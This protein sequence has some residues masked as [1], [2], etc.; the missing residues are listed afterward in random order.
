MNSHRREILIGATLVLLAAL[1]SLSAAEV[2]VQSVPQLSADVIV[3][4]L[5]AANAQR[6][7][8]LRAYRGK[9][10][11]RLDYK[12]LFGTHD[13]ELV[14]EATY[15]APDKKD[16]RILSESGSRLLIN[17]VL[18][19][20]LS[21]E[22]AAQEEQ[23]RKALEITPEN[24]AFSLDQ[25]E[26]T[27]N[28]DFYVLNVKPKGKSP[29]LYRG[30]IW[31]DAHDFAVARMEGEPQKNP[32]IWVTHTHIEYRWANEDGFWLPIRNESVTQVRMGGRGTLVI[33]YSDYQ[34]TGAN[35]V[36]TGQ[37]VGQSQTMPDPSSVT[38]DPH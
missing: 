27:A 1:D 17:R 3:Q 32:S 31:V 35:R 29:Y 8:A 14:V 28:G 25:F 5:V 9:R 33:D 36:A 18:L 20:L 21:S 15:A 13:A 11:Y 22:S 7:Q 37:R 10:V 4:K 19:R 38:A 6:A 23:N 26:H 30:K 2:E 34:I 16:F 24:Y 12:G